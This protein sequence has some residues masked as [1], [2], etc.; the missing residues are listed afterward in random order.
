[1]CY[2]G[3]NIAV[4][5][6]ARC[7]VAAKGRV[8]TGY[9]DLQLPGIAEGGK[10]VEFAQDFGRHESQFGGTGSAA[11]GDDDDRASDV[12]HPALPGEYRRQHGL[13]LGGPVFLVACLTQKTLQRSK[14]LVAFAEQFN[15]LISRHVMVSPRVAEVVQFDRE[16]ADEPG[17]LKKAGSEAVESTDAHARKIRPARRVHKDIFQTDRISDGSAVPGSAVFGSIGGLQA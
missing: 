14:T 4:D 16:S 1:M 15:Y 9:A 2:G 3:D 6:A 7:P 17:C 11:A 12:A 10:I 5:V 13:E 8:L